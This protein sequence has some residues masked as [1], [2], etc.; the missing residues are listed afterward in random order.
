MEDS[1]RKFSAS[2]SIPGL[3]ALPFVNMYPAQNKAVHKSALRRAFKPPS[4]VDKPQYETSKIDQVTRSQPLTSPREQSSA[5][6]IGPSTQPVK[7]RRLLVSPASIPSL[8]PG[9][10]KKDPPATPAPRYEPRAPAPSP[11]PARLPISTTKVV[12][13]VCR[14]WIKLLFPRCRGSDVHSM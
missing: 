14:I 9:P 8:T 7:R 4:F 1:A 11:S 5:Q 2:C 3:L 10:A 12:T 13:A 6:D